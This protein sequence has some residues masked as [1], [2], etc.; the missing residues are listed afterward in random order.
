METIAM[1]LQ[2]ALEL[3]PHYLPYTKEVVN[4]ISQHERVK[5]IMAAVL[6]QYKQHNVPFFSP[7]ASYG[8]RFCEWLNSYY[9]ASSFSYTFLNSESFKEMAAEVERLAAPHFVFAL[10]DRVSKLL[11][12]NP[13]AELV[14]EDHLLNDRGRKLLLEHLLIP[15]ETKNKIRFDILKTIG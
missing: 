8:R 7:G 11:E 12:V 4:Y 2:E 13:S 10:N 5:E 14:L 6:W 1:S 9:Q 3:S 15:E